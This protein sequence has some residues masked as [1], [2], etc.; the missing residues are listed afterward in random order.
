[1]SS[2]GRL[3]SGFIQPLRWRIAWFASMTTGRISVMS[4]SGAGLAKSA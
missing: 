2:V 1:M 4:T 3:R